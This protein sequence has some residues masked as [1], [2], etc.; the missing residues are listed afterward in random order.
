MST[1]GK[2]LNERYTDRYTRSNSDF[3]ETFIQ[4]SQIYS[5]EPDQPIDTTK[6][7]YIEGF[8]EE[9]LLKTD[10]ISDRGD[11]EKN[12]S[13]PTTNHAIFAQTI[14]NGL[15]E[16]NFDKSAQLLISSL[17]SKSNPRGFSDRSVIDDLINLFKK[18]QGLVELPISM[19]LKIGALYDSYYYK[20][21]DEPI[22]LDIINGISGN[23]NRDILDNK[24]VLG[25]HYGTY[26]TKNGEL[27]GIVAPF[28][29]PL[30]PRSID[31]KMLSN[32]DNYSSTN[33]VKNYRPE[34][35]NF[36]NKRNESISNNISSH[37]PFSGYG[38]MNNY[39]NSIHKIF[40]NE[41]LDGGGLNDTQNDNKIPYHIIGNYNGRLKTIKTYN[42]QH[43][44]FMAS[45]NSYEMGLDLDL[46]ELLTEFDEL[47]SSITL[48]DDFIYT[49]KNSKEKLE[50]F[51]ILSKIK[52]NFL[53]GSFTV[54]D[55]YLKI[56]ELC[57]VNN[58]G[59]KEDDKYDLPDFVALLLYTLYPPDG[60][61]PS[62]GLN[63]P[64]KKFKILSKYLVDENSFI[65]T[66]TEEISVNNKGL[67][68]QKEI[69]KL[70]GNYDRI[71]RLV[72]KLLVDIWSN[73]MPK[74]DTRKLKKLDKKGVFV[75][76]PGTG[77]HIDLSST[78][79]DFVTK[80][81]VVST[82]FSEDPG[83]PN[84]ND[85]GIWMPTMFT[86]LE[87][88]DVSDNYYVDDINID[89]TSKIELYQKYEEI[90]NDF[91]IDRVNGLDKTKRDE[92]RK[93]VYNSNSFD[94][95][96]F[97]P[98]SYPTN[99]TTINYF[100]RYDDVYL[101]KQVRSI[102]ASWENQTKAELFKF[103]NKLL[104]LNTPRLLWFETPKSNPS[105][106]GYINRTLSGGNPKDTF[107][108]YYDSKELTHYGFN[109]IGNNNIKQLQDGFKSSGNSVV[110]NTTK[111]IKEYPSGK[112]LY[113]TYQEVK[114]N[115]STD[116][117]KDDYLTLFLG[118]NNDST[119][120]YD[121]NSAKSL[122]DIFDIDKL[123]DFRL[124][125]KRFSNDEGS[126]YFK[127]TFNTFDFKSLL[128]H[129]SMFGYEDI[130]ENLSINDRDFN[131][132][133]IATLLCGYT[134]HFID[135][136][137]NC[138]LNKL[139][140]TA[141][142]LGQ[143]N[144]ARVVIDEFMND[145]ITVNNYSTAGP[146]DIEN[147][148]DN[149]TSIRVNSFL[150]NPLVAYSYATEGGES[151]SYEGIVDQIGD[152]LLFR[153]ILFGDQTIK[154]YNP[155][156]LED[157]GGIEYLIDKYVHFTYSPYM[158]VYDLT[159]NPNLKNKDIVTELTRNFFRQLNIELNIG[160]LQLLVS[161]LRSY[162]NY[163]LKYSPVEF[164][165]T[166]PI[167]DII[168]RSRLEATSNRN[169]EVAETKYDRTYVGDKLPNSSGKSGWEVTAFKEEGSED[170]SSITTPLFE[171]EVNGL[172]DLNMVETFNQWVK[173]FNKR[174]VDRTIKL[175]DNSLE[176]FG[177]VLGD[178]DDI[179]NSSSNIAINDINEEERELRTGTYYRIKTLYDKN[180]SFKN[181]DYTKSNLFTS[182]ISKVDVNEL[183]DTPLFYNFNVQSSDMCEDD[184]SNSFKEDRHGK[185]NEL[186]DLYSYASVL[187]RGNNDYGSK[188]LVDVVGLSSILGTQISTIKD[189]NKATDKSMWS[190][191]SALASEHE[192]LLLP[193]TSYINLSSSNREN[194]SP[195]DLA[196]DMFGVFNELTMWESN[197][198][199]IFQLG[200][201]T[202][203]INDKNSKKKG[204][205]QPFNPSD[206]FCLDINPN[207]L[208]VD[209]NAQILS[210]DMP[211][212]IKNSE[213]TAFIVDF[214][215]A[216]QSMF[217]NIQIS[218]NEFTN[219][220]ESIKASV[221]LSDSTK[222]LSL[223]TG[224]LFS[225]MESRSYTCTV[226]SMGNT[227]LQPLSY[228]YL[229]NVPLFY[230]TYWI[231]NVSH[232]VTPN[233]M[234]TT[235]KGVRQ[236]IIKKP[237]PNKTILSKIIRAAKERSG[238]SGYT[239]RNDPTPIPSSGVL[240]VERGL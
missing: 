217:K 100:D 209:G 127:E 40:F 89:S 131:K 211:S 167:T 133:E 56:E 182:D 78:I 5:S 238:A 119:K 125:Y 39:L 130:S 43:I 23:N 179:G 35:Y 74:N 123:E 101:I 24:D 171:Y 31:D 172:D 186:K 232:K 66:S 76:Y 134:G 14:V 201:L 233:N 180:V 28:V 221:S 82:S 84:R 69:I 208:G 109:F 163:T 193:L 115:R 187:D 205:N 104:L 156:V 170:I 86:K 162:I 229:R 176:N 30:T 37:I 197:P 18:T 121:Y 202:S 195:Y 15:R 178:Y 137:S 152:K 3:D 59:A 117:D 153:T 32:F 128:K 166:N 198:S 113:D 142:T 93:Y 106:G 122:I 145:K 151:K 88:T 47:T 38:V 77:G 29:R 168:K 94:P 220:E 231:T 204:F 196:H 154:P 155:T 188:V 164:S 107:Y 52:A 62:E 234:V 64:N 79:G 58:L 108:G 42:D 21:S 140:N 54:P 240:Y 189:V 181:I 185:N 103:N 169:V 99:S 230:G 2:Y 135:F 55:V 13:A 65:G 218:T 200:S 239:D 126:N 203:E 60:P 136:A 129:L 192:F 235:F 33:I 80:T 174:T 95:E 236:P 9:S 7:E 224:K 81:N 45:Y 184:Y 183:L 173:D 191:L 50:F 199:F 61:E 214:A 161:Y 6:L 22:N 210:E 4:Y 34:F 144:K 222:N 225:A 165:G 139:I 67:S 114:S 146:L 212:D 11:Y 157:Q 68:L 85:A 223:S 206:T 102:P 111:S 19:I 87:P 49:K 159:I 10:E 120:G 75:V 16:G 132:D 27:K 216:N 175:L 91:H 112:G 147:T 8:K 63:R 83:D 44:N 53:S 110:D 20:E 226:T 118:L 237:T 25:T 48:N 90:D 213:V 143:E 97:K 177:K 194:Q 150:F 46:E 215:N 1:L 158:G 116:N 12:P 36:D 71:D 219:T 17:H 98:Q 148:E 73:E 228:F 70:G 105:I 207:E 160:N 124:L 141:I 149:P 26:S 41:G 227:T 190:V 96:Y 92:V 138:G 72:S 51:L 57:S